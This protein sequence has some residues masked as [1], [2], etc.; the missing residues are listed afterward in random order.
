MSTAAEWSR[1]SLRVPST[2]SEMR[3]QIAGTT[4]SSDQANGKKMVPNGAWYV[5]A[6]SVRLPLYRPSP[7]PVDEAESEGEEEEEEE[8]LN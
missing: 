7:E 4:D 2:I 6:R 8:F 3:E 5:W 1:R